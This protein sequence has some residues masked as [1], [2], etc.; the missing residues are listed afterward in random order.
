MVDALGEIHRV[1]APRGTLID[2]R[3]DSRVLAYAERK[4]GKGF[5]RFGLIRTNR[6]ETLNDQASDE[7]I[8][9]VLRQGLFKSKRRGRI[10]HLV[11]FDSLAEL[12]S[13]LW[14]HLRFTRRAEWVVDAKTRRRY[15]N[16]SF[17]V[18]RAVRYE[19]LSAIKATVLS[20]AIAASAARM[21]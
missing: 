3:P 4:R 12:R 6:E 21:Q 10:W 14:H 15:A 20:T 1:L 8:A 17:V 2:A 16:E 5:Q 18:R 13:Y 7:A 9:H 19:V 11:P